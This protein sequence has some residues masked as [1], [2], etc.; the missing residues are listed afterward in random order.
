MATYMHLVG[1][2]G[3]LFSPPVFYALYNI[4]TLNLN[5]EGTA[6]PL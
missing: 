1:A 5:D 4:I 6:A 3:N 2:A